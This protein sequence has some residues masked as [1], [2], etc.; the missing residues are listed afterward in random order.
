MHLL[1]L[2]NSAFYRFARRKALRRRYLRGRLPELPTRCAEDTPF[3]W[4]PAPIRCTLQWKPAS[5]P[6]AMASSLESQIPLRRRRPRRL[7]VP[8]QIRRD[9][10]AVPAPAC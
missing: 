5:K 3:L 7:E 10:S 1:G 8:Y 9:W 6:E 4:I 2:R